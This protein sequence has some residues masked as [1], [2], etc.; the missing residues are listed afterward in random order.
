MQQ[1]QQ[2]QFALEESR[3]RQS[4]S[5][6]WLIVLPAVFHGHANAYCSLKTCMSQE[7]TKREMQQAKQVW[8]Y[9]RNL[10]L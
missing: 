7:E 1:Q 9:L 6:D 8:I 10:V 3:L 4:V 5:S 2:Q